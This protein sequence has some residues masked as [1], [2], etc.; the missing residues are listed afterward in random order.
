M[1][2]RLLLVA[3]A[4]PPPPG[5]RV[6]R[7]PYS[8]IGGGKWQ[9]RYVAARS[10]DGLVA[11]AALPRLRLHRPSNCSQIALPVS[12]GVNSSSWRPW[13]ALDLVDDDEAAQVFASQLRLPQPGDAPK[14]LQIERMV[15][16]ESSSRAW[17]LSMMSADNAVEDE[18]IVIG[19]RE[20][21][22]ALCSDDLR[23][24][25]SCRAPSAGKAR[26]APAPAPAGGY[27]R[28][29]RKRRLPRCRWKPA[30]TRPRRGLPPQPTGAVPAATRCRPRRGADRPAGAPH[31]P[32]RELIPLAFRGGVRGPHL[33]SRTPKGQG[34]KG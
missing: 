27:C 1:G 6:R 21:D 3:T 23:R 18:L 22:A 16:V 31:T 17:G 11:A 26:R 5:H 13:G 12:C 4:L 29:L 19:V 34:I 20:S 10:L 8:I 28:W 7:R 33:A 2:S 15:R 25:R 24:R 14:V 9:S 30:P 32:P